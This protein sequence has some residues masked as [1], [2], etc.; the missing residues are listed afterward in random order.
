MCRLVRRFRSPDLL[1]LILV[2]VGSWMT[3]PGAAAVYKGL[4]ARRYSVE[5][6]SDPSHHVA[7]N[8]ALLLETVGMGV[9]Y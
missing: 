9:K 2:I 8:L 5:R 7:V 3:Y 1:V 6:D 4:E